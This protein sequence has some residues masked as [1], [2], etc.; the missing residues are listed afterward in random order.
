MD[1]TRPLQHAIKIIDRWLA[2]NVATD[3]R[4]PGLSFG[5][6]YGDKVIYSRGY[7]Y[8]DLAQKIP[9]GETTCYR[10]ASFS[11]IFTTIAVM[12]LQEQGKL[13]LDDRVQRYLPWFTSANDQHLDAITVRQLLTHTAGLDRDGDTTHWIDFQ[14]PALP[15]IQR[16]VGEGEATVYGPL[17]HWKYSNY[18]FTLLGEII[19]QVSGVSYEEYVTSHIVERLGLIHTAPMLTDDI[20]KHLALGYSRSLPGQEKEPFPAIETHVMASATGFSSTVQDLCQLMMAFFDGDTRLL[21]DETKREMRRIQWLREEDGNDWCVGLGT[22]KVNDRRLYGHGGSFPGYKSRFG[23]DPQSTIGVVVLA[24]AIDAP[25]ADIVN[26]IWET[27]NYFV[28]HDTEF[29]AGTEA[30]ESADA[31]EGIYRNIWGDVEVISIASHLLF[32]EPGPHAPMSD[33]DRL[34]YKQ[35]G[36]YKITSGNSFGHVGELVRFEK[37]G[38]RASRIFIGANPSTRLDY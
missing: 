18:G 35:D 7:G 10:I 9:A 28:A 25:S 3:Q 27:I 15:T 4:I 2:Y 14:F 8:A 34:Q 33:L 31:Y 23:F 22:W 5:L 29:E 13:A 17:E 11:K 26:K 12:Q 32:Y 36:V 1:F 21:Q 30:L 24:N 16:Y 19:K 38:D 20:L 6:V 37:E